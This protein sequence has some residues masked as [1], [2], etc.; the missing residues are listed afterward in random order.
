MAKRSEGK[1]DKVLPGLKPPPVEDFT[2]QSR[3]DEVKKDITNRA[4]VFLGTSYALLRVKKKL[5]ENVL[6]DINLHIAA[7]EQLL[8]ES[9][10]IQAAGWGDYG[11]TENT[12][13]LETGES[14]RVQAEPTSQVKD[15][16]AY[17]LWCI[18]NGYERQMGLWPSTTEAIVKERLLAG[19]K[20]PDGCE[21]YARTKIVFTKGSE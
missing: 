21:V 17:R 10:E 2:Y 13:R 18:E 3:V 5:A 8:V 4:A 11:A 12:L 15:K 6:K 16:E 7:H 19:E 20:P 9:Q 14:I 1:Y